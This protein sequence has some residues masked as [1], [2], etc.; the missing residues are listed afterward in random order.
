MNFKQLLEQITTEF[1]G[2]IKGRD[3][4]IIKQKSRFVVFIEGEKLDRFN[5]LSDA[6]NAATEFIKLAGG[7]K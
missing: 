4:Y 7:S 1:K 3:V 2:K 5:T 6:K